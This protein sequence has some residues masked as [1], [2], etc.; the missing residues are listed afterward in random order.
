MIRCATP[1]CR[2]KAITGRRRCAKCRSRLYAKKHP[3][4]YH[5]NLQ[6]QNAKRR[7]HE[8]NLTFDQW[9]AVWDQHPEKWEDK[10]KPGMCEWQMDRIDRRLGYEVGNV[11]ILHKTRHVEKTVAENK[12]YMDVKWNRKKKNPIEKAPF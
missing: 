1:N 7:G 6:K 2:S 12:F 10:L 3:H 4:R 8:F 5:F 11:Q 9:K